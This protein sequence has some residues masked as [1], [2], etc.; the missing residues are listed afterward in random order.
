MA[1]HL[2]TQFQDNPEA[3]TRADCILERSNSTQ[4]K[5]FALRILEKFIQTRW[6]VLPAES[7]S[8]I[9]NFIGNI[10]VKVSSDE[11]TFTREKTYVRKLNMV[12]VQILKQDWPGSWPGFVP[13]IVASSKSN[14][15]ICENNMNI[16]KILSEEIFDFSEQMTQAKADSLRKC[17]CSQF[18]AIYQLCKE[19]L[20]CAKKPELIKVT[21]ETLL[22]FLSWIPLGY[23]FETDLVTI[24]CNKYLICPEYRIATLKCLTEIGG[25]CVQENY[26]YCRKFGAMFTCAMTHINKMVPLTKDFESCYATG[27]DHCDEFLLHLALFLTS[28]L[29]AHV[30]VIEEKYPN[31]KLLINAH[32]YLL[33]I[34]RV[35][36]CEIFKICLEY[37]RSLVQSLYEDYRTK[38]IDGNM[39]AEGQH[40]SRARKF[41]Y[42]DVLTN[43]RLLM[44][45]RMVKPEEVLIMENEE[46]VIVREFM[47]ECDTIVLHRNM[48][49]VLVYL[50]NLDV[51]EMER[52][53]TRKLAKQ[54]DGSEFSWTNLNQLC[55]AIGAISGAMSVE[56]EKTFLIEVIKSLLTLCEL[57]PGK[58]NKAV[59]TSN[60]IYTVGQYPRFLGA[61]YKF[62][63]TVVGKVFEFMHETHEGVQDMACDTFL[64]IAQ[65]CK[66]SFILPP[67]SDQPPMI[68]EILVNME[69]ITSSL[70]PCQMNVFYQA[71]G[72]LI[73]S[74][75]SYTIQVRLM[76]K[77]MT[78]PNTAWI[79]IMDQIRQDRT[80]LE[81]PTTIKIL[82]NVL[83]TNTAVCASAGPI[84]GIQFGTIHADLINL[85]QVSD[86]IMEAQIAEKGALAVKLPKVRAVRSI[87]KDILK[88]FE[89]YVRTA[90]DL[91]SLTE[92][93]MP[94]I[95]NVA[96]CH[97]RSTIEEARDAEVL[98]MTAALLDRVGPLASM[99]VP[100][101]LQCLFESTLTMIS[102]DFCEYPEHRLGF[103]SLLRAINRRC[104]KALL[105]LE[106][107]TFKLVIDSIIWGFK[108]TMRDI[109]EISLELCYDLIQNVSRCDTATSD[110]FYQSYYLCIMQDVFFVLTD[111]DHKSGFKGQ[112]EVLA[113]L[114]QLVSANA[115]KAPLYDVATV[116]KPGMSNKEF[117]YDYVSELMQ[118]AFPH[119]KSAQIKVFVTSLF[120]YNVNLVKFKTEVRDFLIQL[121]EFAGDTDDLYIEEKEAEL[122]QQRKAKLAKALAIPGMVKPA[123]L[124]SAMDEDGGS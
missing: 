25:L 15:T 83:S 122:E 5:F 118:N 108:H 24:L 60:I 7:R 61:H 85:Y 110:A 105:S 79:A 113:R 33:K 43:L 112:T 75:Q 12:L 121:N 59:I 28:F 45:E 47:R 11:E 34:S 18:A 111:T 114:F 99:K 87:K 115:I 80:S 64:K 55:W 71:I 40:D 63:K 14:L 37:W 119:L 120:E 39:Q 42:K 30:K 92:G 19:V 89:R 26:N 62:L 102:N 48:K 16:L 8:A 84:Y 21:L 13:E 95:M 56:S 117:L 72:H 82:R 74:E 32:I 70:S 90:E 36:D 76:T 91:E 20:D 100:C 50:T 123:D 103:Y 101:I 51:K 124:P 6:K 10:I 53:M 77:L 68:N 57:K 3:W 65:H 22:K 29:G 44:I 2:L 116:S 27:I 9:R 106:T 38:L 17:M 86:E 67:T 49:E 1:Q 78:A 97:Y 35:R 73:S 94:G 96:L 88:L 23:I 41:L 31:P 58:D 107:S 98:N 93:V 4:S 104:F 46:G 54:M 69:S 81:E 109:S 66:R 52:I